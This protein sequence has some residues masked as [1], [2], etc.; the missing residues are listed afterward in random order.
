M[1]KKDNEQKPVLNLDDKEYVIDD[2]T[3]YQKQILDDINNYQ[4]Q[5][6]R[7]DRWKAGHVHVLRESLNT[8]PNPE[9]G[10][11]EAEA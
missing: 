4:I 7:L 9:A 3:D 6:N 2:M 5:I 10:E 11:A 1:A 8:K